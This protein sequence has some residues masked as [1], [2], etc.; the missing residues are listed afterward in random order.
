MGGDIC[1]K[2]GSEK[3]EG[4]KA[5]LSASSSQFQSIFDEGPDNKELVF[6]SELVTFVGLKEI[7]KY[8]GYGILNLTEDNICHIVCSAIYFDI[9]C[10][11]P[12]LLMYINNLI[13]IM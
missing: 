7:M 1:F 12:K 9:D 6:P 13:I 2:Y 10:I 5:L 8:F 4:I 11:M 3:I